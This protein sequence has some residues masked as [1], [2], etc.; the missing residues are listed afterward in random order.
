M[1]AVGGPQAQAQQQQQQQQAQQAQP[2]LPA[3][4]VGATG[5]DRYSGNRQAEEF[6][7]QGGKLGSLVLCG[8]WLLEPAGHQ[9][10]KP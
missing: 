1:A 8:S 5:P 4:Q 10:P 9:L 6:L 3:Q 7:W 2:P